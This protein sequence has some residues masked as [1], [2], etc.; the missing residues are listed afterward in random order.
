[1]AE[2]LVVGG[3][4]GGVVAAVE[5]RKRLGRS[6][7]VTLV[8][9]GGRHVFAPSFLWV[10][11][12]W[13]RPEQVQRDLTLLSRRG[14]RTTIAEVRRVDPVSRI[15]ETTAG[16]LGYDRLVLAPGAELA[17]ELLPGFETG[18]RNLYTLEGLQKLREDLATFRK[19]RVVVLISRTPFKCPAAPYEAAFLLDYHFRRSGIRDSVSVDLVTPEPQPMP[20][21]GPEVGKSLVAMLSA[22][23]I[24]YHPQGKP[25]RI[26]P[27]AR[28]IALESGE[29]IPYDLLVGVPPHR[30]PAF[31]RESGLTDATGWVP[32]DPRTLKTSANGVY[33][34][35]DVAS[36]KL[37]NGMFL[38]KAGV[39]AHGQAEAV[40]KTIAADLTS[41]GE[42]K[43]F[44]GMGYCW[45]ET[46]FGKAAFGSGDFYASP[47]PQVALRPSARYL[48]WGK[49]LFEKYWFWKWF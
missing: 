15:V 33:A 43:T 27:E 26:D 22:R 5:L 30:A 16:P 18:A 4:I 11:M 45:V 38:P 49:V 31:V 42:A 37:P 21:A 7:G 44:D 23:G 12:G 32:V 2:V 40:A 1:M 35:G 34:I 36:L 41:R 9:K 10:M 19:G 3:G 24:N 17:P 14:I 39:F 6:H 13:R 8:D 47:S 20:V 48:R 46:G 28:E 25:S 29:R